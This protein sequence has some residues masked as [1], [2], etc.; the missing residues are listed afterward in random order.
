MYIVTLCCSKRFIT[1]E[2]AFAQELRK[3]G[4]TVMEPPLAT[5]ENWE[6]IHEKERI[7]LAAGL[8]LRHFE[9]I[10]KADAIVVLNKDGY[11]GVSTSMEIGYA[12]ALGKRIFY[13][14]DDTDYPRKVLAE[15]ITKTPQEV[16]DRLKDGKSQ[17][18]LA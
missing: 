9:K 17:D 12:A 11:M 18:L 10:R 3:L 14:E 13:V 7:A 8:T 6:K 15:D 1:E 2:R 5:S 16:L 4:I